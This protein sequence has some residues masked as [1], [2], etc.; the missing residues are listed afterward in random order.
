MDD[1]PAMTNEVIVRACG[2]A[3]WDAVLSLL[4]DV[5][6]GEGYVPPDHAH[7]SYT[8]E[9]LTAGGLVLV[10]CDASTVLGVVV[11]A[12][13]GGPLSS[14]AAPG[15]AEFRMLA[16]SPSGRGRGIGEL[17]VKSCIE[18]AS[19]APFSAEKLVLWTQPSMTAAQRLY[20]RL[21]F[22]RV[23]ERDGD[24]PPLTEG[25]PPITQLV[26]ARALA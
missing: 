17:L 4:R 18:H 15:E 20:E 26:Y 24:R 21:G 2:D 5:Y 3:D 10:A 13:P 9:R 1:T 22:A 6:A 23:P 11:L 19:L 25:S 16:V 8:R 7:R 12:F 14:I